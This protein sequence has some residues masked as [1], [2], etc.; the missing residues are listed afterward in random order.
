M[1][2][3]AM[4]IVCGLFGFFGLQNSA[5]SD[6]PK[7]APVDTDVTNFGDWRFACAQPDKKTPKECRISQRVSWG[8]D[9]DHQ[10]SMSIVMFAMDE[11]SAAASKAKEKPIVLMRVIMPLGVDL[12]PGLGVA[13]GKD[14]KPVSFPYNI[15]LPSG[16]IATT[17]LG[18]GIAGKI[19]TADNM[20]I[21]YKAPGSGKPVGVKLSTKGLGQAYD[22]LIK[23]KKG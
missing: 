20:T 8:R 9:K 1:F 18:A 16:C 7:A 23:A 19:R 6:T 13:V 17:G 15:C 22:A 4:I 11:K 2:F 10:A 12:R 3:T 14:G 21:V 5:F